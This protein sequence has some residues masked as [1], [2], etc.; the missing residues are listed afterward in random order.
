MKQI[1]PILQRL[2]WTV[3]ALLIIH[4]ANA[5]QLTFKTNQSIA[6]MEGAA[7]AAYFLNG[8]RSAA[9]QNFNIHYMRCVWQVDPAIRYING[10]ITMYYEIS[11]N[12]NSITLD[13]K[14]PLL[15]DS[16]IQRNNQLTFSQPSDLLTINFTNTVSAG[17][18]DSIT[19]FYKGIPPNTG[20]GSFI[21]TAHNGVPVMWT[22]SEP[23]GARDWFPC[24]NGLDNKT[25]SVDLY[26]I[27]PSVYKA[28]SNGLL[29]YEQPYDAG[30]TITY[31]KHRYPIA[32]YLICFAVTNYEVFG[33]TVQLLN[34]QMPMVTYCYPESRSLFESN[35][36]KVQDA[37]QL[38]D[39]TWGE[40]P[41][42]NEKYGHVQFGWGGG[43]EHQTSTFII[44]PEE[45]LMAHELGHQWFGD[46]I[47][48][49]SWEDIWLNEG[50]ATHLAAFYMEKKYPAS[51]IANRASVLNNIT[52]QIGGSV[53]V[54]DT[55][56]VNRIFSNR[57]TYNKGSYLVY[58]LR[59]KLGDSAFFRGIRQ[60]QSDP[61]IRY[62]FARTTD[63]KRNLEEVS[64]VSL[65]Q[66]FRQWYEG[67]GYP[68]YNIQ[69]NSFGSSRVKIKVNQTTSHPSVSFF[70]MPVPLL[71]KNA[72]QQKLI[73]V[74][75]VTNG[76]IFIENIG[77]I[78]D[79][80]L[81][82]P[83]LWLISKNNSTQKTAAE[84]GIAEISIY[85]NP[86]TDPSRILIQDM[87]AASAQLMV[88]NAAGQLVI[89]KTIPLVNG[90]AEYFL[91]VT[92]LSRG[93]Y[94]IQ[95]VSGNFRFAKQFIR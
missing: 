77:F 78:P 71:F 19:V 2:R 82:D 62:G 51:V 81:V 64:G 59:L 36:S 85:P 41:F 83:E 35:T 24:K 91:P 75:N 3:I 88:Y 80:V 42:K 89:K 63:L 50:F 34:R 26:I 76:E 33:N 61:T 52:S 54:N 6:E 14:S 32:T 11:E 60:Y 93:V 29:Q 25:D 23:Y 48:C 38:F 17:T 79:T 55:T 8:S 70:A 1:L 67:E 16:V 30:R 10:A 28:A 4:S 39:R 90:Y 53:K 46:K 18:K 65:T 45:S 21:N 47:T 58:M 43:M 7:R 92:Q 49:A 86:L 66:F 74:N 22:L 94:H 56:S 15:T 95:I 13:L 37:L 27:H 69:W 44:T 5:Q 9:S 73:T 40:Y 72:T 57:L 20:F 87:N 84:A 12:T 31:W 68:T